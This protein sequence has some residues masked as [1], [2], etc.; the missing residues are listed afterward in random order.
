MCVRVSEAREAATERHGRD[1]VQGSSNFT[2]V[3]TGAPFG[4]EMRRS[5]VTETVNI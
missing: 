3:G 1:G 4:A 5:S 2:E